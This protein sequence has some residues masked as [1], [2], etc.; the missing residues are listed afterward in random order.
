MNEFKIGDVVM[1]KSGGP[2]MTVVGTPDEGDE[3][4]DVDVA[5][6]SQESALVAAELPSDALGFVDASHPVPQ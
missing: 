3:N 4:Q 1:L 6:F 2:R 5:W